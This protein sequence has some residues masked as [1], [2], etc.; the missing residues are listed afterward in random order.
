MSLFYVIRN[1]DLWEFFQNIQSPSGSEIY[2]W[3]HF[4]GS[5]WGYINSA[6]TLPL[7]GIFF[8]KMCSCLPKWLFSVYYIHIYQFIT[9]STPLLIKKQVQKRQVQVAKPSRVYNC[10]GLCIILIHILHMV[11]NLRL[12]PNTNNPPQLLKQKCSAALYILL[13]F[14]LFKSH[15]TQTR[16]GLAYIVTEKKPKSIKNKTR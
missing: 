12:K 1:C 15:K 2:H 4:F 7:P 9:D 16:P 6:I 5:G 8:N 11:S 3:L 13:V 10:R 14:Y